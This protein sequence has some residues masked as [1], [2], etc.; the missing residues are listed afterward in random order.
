MRRSDVPGGRAQALPLG[1]PEKPPGGVPVPRRGPT[2]NFPKEAAAGRDASRKNGGD[3]ARL[4]AYMQDMTFVRATYFW[5]FSFPR[6]AAERGC[7]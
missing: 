2:G 1:V 6:Q 7:A 3:K 5:Y 4:P